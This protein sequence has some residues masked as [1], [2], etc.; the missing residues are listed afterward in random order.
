MYPTNISFFLTRDTRSVW[1]IPHRTS[2]DPRRKT[3]KKEKGGVQKWTAPADIFGFS[4]ACLHLHRQAQAQ[5]LLLLRSAPCSAPCPCSL[6]P[7][8]LPAPCF[9]CEQETGQP[10]CTCITCVPVSP[11][12][13][14]TC[15]TCSPVYL[16]HVMNSP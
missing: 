15:V 12:H 14:C 4:P 5:P 16:C 6:S 3:E 1:V 13:L 10:L 8:P 11:V 9:L 7:A 2:A